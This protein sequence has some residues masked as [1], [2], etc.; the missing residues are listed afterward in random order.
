MQDNAASNSQTVQ[1][2]TFLRKGEGSARFGVNG[3][4]PKRPQPV[5]RKPGTSG[6]SSVVSGKTGGSN[7]GGNRQLDR[8]QVI[9]K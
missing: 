3:K 8:K 5:K 6:K 1:K 7:T 4:P 9:T 2:K